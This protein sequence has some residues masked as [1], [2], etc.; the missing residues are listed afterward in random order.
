M[1][2][3]RDPRVAHLKPHD[4]RRTVQ[5]GA[6]QQMRCVTVRGGETDLQMRKLTLSESRNSLVTI[7][8]ARVAWSRPA[9][10]RL[11]FT[12]GLEISRFGFEI[13]DSGRTRRAG[14]LRGRWRRCSGKSGR[15]ITVW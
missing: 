2:V 9:E 12:F 15:G 4:A 14:R 13:Q 11:S 10:R 8:E 7:F 6:T 1:S 5:N 3:T